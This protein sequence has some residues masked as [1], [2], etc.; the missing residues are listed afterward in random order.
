MLAAEVA[1][2]R[3]AGGNPD[4]DIDV[5]ETFVVLAQPLEP[6]EHL[7]RAVDR[8]SRGIFDLIRRAPE[9]HDSVTHQLVQ[10]AF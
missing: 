6:F 7:E 3:V 10:R 2:D 9:R 8:R 5:G 4:A 1:Y